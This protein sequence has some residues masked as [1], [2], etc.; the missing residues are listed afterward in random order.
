MWRRLGRG[1]GRRVAFGPSPGLGDFGERVRGSGG[2]QGGG[3]TPGSE[4]AHLSCSLQLWGLGR[5]SLP[6]CHRTWGT[7]LPGKDTQR[8]TYNVTS[9]IKNKDN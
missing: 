6:V 4:R 1:R 8:D 2:G 3:V 7:G 9:I 5:H